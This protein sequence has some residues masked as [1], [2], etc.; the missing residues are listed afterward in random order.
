[1]TEQRANRVA[2][3]V[4]GVLAVV[5]VTL[6]ALLWATAERG[7]SEPGTTASGTTTGQTTT[8]TVKVAG[9]SYVPNRIEVPAGNRLVITFENTGDAVHDLV[10]ASGVGT[11]RLAPGE[12]GTVDAGVI[13]AGTQAWCTI[14][15]HR[16]MGMS[17]DIV[18]VGGASPSPSHT[19]DAAVSAPTMAALMEQAALTPARDAALPS[20]EPGTVH[21]VTLTVTESTE[22]IAEGVTRAVWTYNGTTPGPILHG[23][24]GDTFRVTLVNDGTMGH[25]IDFH[26]GELAPDEP[27]RTIEPGESLVYAFTADRPGIWMYH[28]STMPMSQHIASGMFGAV[29]IEPDDLTPVDR[30]YVLVESE[31]YLGANG[32]PAN[33]DKLAALAPDVMAFNG[34]AFQ[35]VEHPLPVRSG[36]RVRVWVLNAGPNEA[37]SFHV[38]GEQFDRV[39]TEGVDTGTTGAQVLPLL[40]AQGGFV[41]FTAGEPGHYAFVNHAMSLSEK[42]AQGVFEVTD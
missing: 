15:G 11:D 17:L 27:M 23:K 31:I 29:V 30:S 3:A 28:C 34:R 41:E 10:L 42:G 32:E 33:T 18:A 26:A 37:L 16:A 6:A 1:M 35:Y 21:D 2:Q 20:L 25:S 19:D 39:W 5:L 13:T 12:S 38:V 7:G 24:V 9:M 22:T 40:P 4:I 8:V 14:A 36:E